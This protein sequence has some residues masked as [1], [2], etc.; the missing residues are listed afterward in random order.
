VEKLPLSVCLIVR[1]DGKFMADALESVEG[2]ASEVIIINSLPTDTLTNPLTFD[3]A[4]GPNF[5]GELKSFDFPWNNDYSE[6]KNFAL[7]KATQPWILIFDADYV[8]SVESQNEVARC[9][10][11]TGTSVFYLKFIENYQQNTSV[12]NT[13]TKEVSQIN[14]K[15][16][17]IRNGLGIKFTGRVFERLCNIDNLKSETEEIYLLNCNN[18]P[19]A[20]TEKENITTKLLQ[21]ALS[22]DIGINDRIFYQSKLITLNLY[23]DPE[24]KEAIFRFNNLLKTYTLDKKYFEQWYFDVTTFLISKNDIGTALDILLDVSEQ[25]PESIGLFYN[26]YQL[27]FK[28]AK[29]FEC[30]R[31]LNYI[32]YLK[33]NTKGINPYCNIPPV[34]LNEDFLNHQLTRC[35]LELNDY[36][37]ANYSFKAVNEQSRYESDL[38]ML[39]A[40]FV[41]N[42]F[43][44]KS[45]VDKISTLNFTILK[46]KLA[47]EYV[48]AQDYGKAIIIYFEI[49]NKAVREDDI[50]YEKLVY[51][52]LLLY[53][54]ALVSD[55]NQLIE[56]G[57]IKYHDYSDFW[58]S[59]GKYYFSTGFPD[60]AVVSF[61]KAIQI[62]EKLER[63]LPFLHIRSR[64]IDEPFIDELINKLNDRFVKTKAAEAVV[65][66]KSAKSNL[67]EDI[68]FIEA[69]EFWKNRQIEKAIEFFLLT[70]PQNEYENYVVND[71]LALAYE[72]LNDN[73]NSLDY[74]GKAISYYP[75]ELMLNRQKISQNK[76]YAKIFETA[77][78]E[79]PMLQNASEWISA[80]REIDK[81]K[82]KVV[83]EIGTYKGGTIYTISQLV[84]KATIITIDLPAGGEIY[85]EG[86]TN[87][88]Q[89]ELKRKINTNNHDNEIHFIRNDSHLENTLKNVKEILNGNEVDILFLD[90]DHSYE[91]VKK[92][93]EMY[94]P[95]VRHDG[96]IIMHDIHPLNVLIINSPSDKFWDKVGVDQFWQEISKKY[97]A[98]EFIN[99]KR[100]RGYGIGIIKYT[101]PD[102]D[103]Y[104]ELENLLENKNLSYFEKLINLLTDNFAEI[105][106]NGRFSNT[107]AVTMI[108]LKR[109]NNLRFCIEQVIENKIT[110]DIL[111]AGVWRGG[112]SI[113]ARSVLE[114][115]SIRDKKVYV[116]DSF[117]G[118]PEPDENYPSDKGSVFHELTYLSISEAEVK[119]NFKKFKMLDE[120]VIFLKGWF[121]DT[122]K[123]PPFEKL[124][125]LRLDGD[126]YSSTWETLTLLYDKVSSGG[127]IIVDDY[128]I[129]NCKEAVDQFRDMKNI[130][131]PI[132]RIDWTGAFWQKE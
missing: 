73:N 76:K 113:L 75:D 17:L 27:L 8:L 86:M 49:L 97:Q 84:N 50:I 115:Y 100:Q 127:Y 131:S 3:S 45:L 10:D 132:E 31:I 62:E 48:R 88:E 85:G 74:I 112:A 108:G 119:S 87:N 94:S 30:T 95:L 80:L 37:A 41:L 54:K 13:E 39:E 79:F 89:A 23:T 22:E 102:F 107:K 118:L 12:N 104:R 82:P 61:Q 64:K 99:D 43:R 4:Q 63:N 69:L 18:S 42:D 32:L 124:A 52:D 51:C 101:R 2:I 111:E 24:I 55:I 36:P 121:K 129:R 109:L 77:Q 105:F 59:L 53:G 98:S 56:N 130:K 72:K 5:R 93:F 126:M 11:K 46:F 90:G 117:Q 123:E 68:N 44:I 65:R 7:A 34:F 70:N 92:D 71:Y 26:F 25:Y 103:Y 47:R 125:I 66:A 57:K 120:Q 14:Y 28:M 33:I 21:L 91:G 9:L 60:E 78:V 19:E 15:E 58:L 83:L 67:T 29:I 96:V 114:F 81:V 106:V 20:K 128:G 6:V 40:C 38:V 122:F 16:A 116:C 35:Y 1:G 110:G